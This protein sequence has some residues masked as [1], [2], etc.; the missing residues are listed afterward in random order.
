MNYKQGF[1]ATIKYYRWKMAI[2]T[3]CV[4]QVSQTFTGIIMTHCVSTS[5]FIIIF[6]TVYML[7]CN[8]VYVIK[9]LSKLLDA[10]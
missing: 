3:F 1:I 9:F 2:K 7:S 4:H 5:L 8:Y 6:Y 10:S